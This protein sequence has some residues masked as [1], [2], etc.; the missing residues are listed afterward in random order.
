MVI[1]PVPGSEPGAADAVGGGDAGEHGESGRDIEILV[2]IAFVQYKGGDLKLGA[3]GPQP[4]SCVGCSA[5][6]GARWR[7]HG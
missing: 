1:A 7:W 3:S 5:F 4:T 2:P 6:C